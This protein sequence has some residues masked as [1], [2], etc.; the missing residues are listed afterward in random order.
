MLDQLYLALEVS[1]EKHGRSDM[2]G[3]LNKCQ[4]VLFL[5]PTSSQF[6]TSP[7]YLIHLQIAIYIPG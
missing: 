7:E 5:A 2:R 4:R 3:S 1:I 6:L